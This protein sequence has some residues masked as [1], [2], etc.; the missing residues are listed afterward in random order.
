MTSLWFL[1]YSQFYSHIEQIRVLADHC[2][3]H[4]IEFT[5]AHSISELLLGYAPKA[6]ALFHH[7]ASFLSIGIYFDTIFQPVKF[8]QRFATGYSAFL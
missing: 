5:P 4:L 8:F 7:I 3:V 1:L 6:V 2:A